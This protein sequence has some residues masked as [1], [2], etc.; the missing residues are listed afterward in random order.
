VN[1]SIVTT[2]A[3]DPVIIIERLFDAPRALVFKV[4]TDPYHL[5][6]FWGPHGSTNPVCEMD[7]RPGGLWRQVMRFPDGTEYAYDSA[8][9]EIVEPERIVYRDVPLGTAVLDGLPPPQMITTIS[10]EDAGGRTKLTAHVRAT[11]I[12][13]R[14]KA[15]Q[16]GFATTVSQGNERLAAYL[17]TLQAQSPDGG[18]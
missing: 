6:Q 9:I 5:A 13:A 18:R 12:A 16:M 8:Y 10:F 15:V 11:S 17:A 4:F 1:S 14:D 3:D 2:P 7:V